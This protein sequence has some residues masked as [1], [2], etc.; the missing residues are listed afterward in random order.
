MVLPLVVNCG[1]FME[2]GG[3]Q[4]VIAQ[5]SS[6]RINRSTDNVDLCYYGNV[7]VRDVNAS[8]RA[9]GCYFEVCSGSQ[10]VRDSKR[11]V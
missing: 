1:V 3:I 7:V 10:G 8:K 4:S 2:N 11:E 6:G 5:N 9:G